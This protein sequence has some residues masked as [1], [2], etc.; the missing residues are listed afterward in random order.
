MLWPRRKD[1]DRF[2]EK[3]IHKQK[4]EEE[5]NMPQSDERETCLVEVIEENIFASHI[6]RYTGETVTVFVATG[7]MAGMGFTGILLDAN[8]IFVRLLTQVGAVPACSIDNGC[9]GPGLFG[10]LAGLYLH[11]FY[12]LS[13]TLGVIADIPVDK[14]TAFVHNAV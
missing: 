9:I 11:G 1:D 4:N 12:G 3:G 2:D 13:N 6:A 8:H 5:E 10:I 7:W 14:I